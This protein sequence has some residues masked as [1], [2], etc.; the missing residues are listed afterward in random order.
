M[1]WS[2]PKGKIDRDPGAARRGKGHHYE[3]KVAPFGG[4]PAARRKSAKA[5]VVSGII[6]DMSVKNPPP[7]QSPPL[8]GRDQSLGNPYAT[9]R[10]GGLDAPRV[11]KPSTPRPPVSVKRSAKPRKDDS[12]TRN[13]HEGMRIPNR[14]PSVRPTPD[15]RPMSGAD[16][17]RANEFVSAEPGRKYRAFKDAEKRGVRPTRRSSADAA[18][19]EALRNAM[20]VAD[21]IRAN[22][23]VS[24][25]PGRKYRAFKDAGK[26]RKRN[27]K[28]R[29]STAK[30][31]ALRGFT[32]EWDEVSP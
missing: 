1:A 10:F 8:S 22:E 15:F 27:P 18:K 19:R 7:K 6:G 25:E 28:S 30:S 13:P 20:D 21:K 14:S 16:K 26:P 2:F 17:I 11:R 3:P 31:R 9:G 5:I 24:A 29:K 12:P 32:N 4:G 23:F